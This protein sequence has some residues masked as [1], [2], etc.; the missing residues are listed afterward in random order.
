MRLLGYDCE[1][2]GL[3]TAEDRITEIGVAVWDTELSAPLAV[4]SRFIWD[5]HLEA[6]LTPEVQKMMQELCGITPDMLL[7]FGAPAPQVLSW[8]RQLPARHSID[9]IVAHSGENFDRPLLAAEMKRHLSPEECASF[10]TWP[11]IDTRADIPFPSAPDS[12]K[13][14]HL[15]LDHGFINPFPHRA[16]FDVLTMLRVLSHY[17]IDEV[18]AYSQIPWVTVQALVSYDDRQL[19]KDQRYFWENLGDQK[20]PKC[21][22]KRVKENQLEAEAEACKFAIKVLAQ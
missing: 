16:I 18:I 3:S 2:T 11:W 7:E 12:L 4:H 8:L 21:W 15:A 9:Y 13:L 22:V 17:P 5:E 6:K 10:A 20:Y 1:T 14:K 19:A